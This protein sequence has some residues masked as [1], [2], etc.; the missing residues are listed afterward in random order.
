M[1]NRDKFSECP[2]PEMEKFLDNNGEY[3]EEVEK[4][5]KECFVSELK[6]DLSQPTEKLSEKAR[7]H[8]SSFLGKQ[9][10]RFDGPIELTPDD[11]K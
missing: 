1:G 9:K 5:I 11:L 7:D 6:V 2:P 8:N 4:M 3:T 10:K